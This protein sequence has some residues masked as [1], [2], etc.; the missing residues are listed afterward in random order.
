MFIY[1]ILKH[2]NIFV[3]S[4]IKLITCTY[5]TRAYNQ[6]HLIQSMASVLRFCCF[7]LFEFFLFCVWWHHDCIRVLLT[8]DNPISA[9]QHERGPRTSTLRRQVAMYLRDSSEYPM[10]YP[11]AIVPYSI[12]YIPPYPPTK[13]LAI[14]DTEPPSPVPVPTPLHNVILQPMPRVSSQVVWCHMTIEIHR[15]V[16]IFICNRA[17]WILVWKFK[18]CLPNL[19]KKPYYLKYYVNWQFKRVLY[20]SMHAKKQTHFL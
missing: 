6:Q 15:N 8:M 13:H 17:V 3:T 12:P 10:I 20:C 7:I 9:V 18:Q 4:W 14:C 1:L 11:Q 2:C 5:M 19:P 16:S